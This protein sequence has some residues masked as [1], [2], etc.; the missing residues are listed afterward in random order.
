MSWSAPSW[1]EAAREYHALR[2]PGRPMSK[3][4]YA[5]WRCEAGFDDGVRNLTADAAQS[6]CSEARVLET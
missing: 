2:G 6:A 5:R 3:A 4:D 1:K